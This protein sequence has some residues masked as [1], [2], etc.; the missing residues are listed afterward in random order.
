MRKV[1]QICCFAKKKGKF[2]ALTEIIPL[3][4]PHRSRKATPVD[5]GTARFGWME[6][7][8]FKPGNLMTLSKHDLILIACTRETPQ[9]RPE[10]LQESLD[11]L[12]LR[13]GAEAVVAS[14]S[15]P[16]DDE[17][18]WFGPSVMH[19]DIARVVVVP[20][21]LSQIAKHDLRASVWFQ[22]IDSSIPIFLAEPPTPREIAGWIRAASAA[23]ERDTQVELV[24]PE[25]REPESLDRVAAIAYW[26]GSNGSC[27]LRGD[28]N[29]DS[30]APT[31]YSQ[32]LVAFSSQ[33][34]SLDDGSPACGSVLVRD[35]AIRPWDWL[36]PKSLATW[37]IGRYLH[38]LHASPLGFV[39][40]AQDDLLLQ[41]L[42]ALA[43]RQQALL[44]REYAGRL[45]EIA[46]SSMGSATL[47]YD[48]DGRVPWDRIWTSFC[49]LAMAGGPPHRGRLLGYVSPEEV[50]LRID[51]YRRVVAELRR[52]IGLASGLST[53]E[54]ESLGWVGVQCHDET[55]A[56]W[57][58]R[59]IIV[60]NILVRREGAILYLP[61]GPD[62][63][64]EKEIK[65]VITAVAKTTHYWFAHL[66]MRQPPK[67]L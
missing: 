43:D 11:E 2:K 51:D 59:A 7:R 66:K 1:G 30:D 54:S 15:D 46:P 55:M 65:N 50:Q 4:I 42:K 38:A 10:T 6:S 48:A 28:Q 44:P 60:E 22:G 58:L 18:R 14:L 21:A 36:S 56:A 17:E 49:D 13:L 37:I 52:G 35:G 57:M 9:V 62:F 64:V 16:S 25:P 12:R 67:P 39:D 8:I 5:L 20:F 24:L 32:G 23:L 41:S 29:R 31:P 19:A 34:Y 63:R 33:P 26:T 40:D 27:R 53:R 61:A 47:V 3:P 45:D